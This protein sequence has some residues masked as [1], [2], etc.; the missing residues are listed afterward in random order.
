MRKGE[1]TA[2]EGT[3]GR[4]AASEE[5]RLCSWGPGSRDSNSLGVGTS[6]PPSPSQPPPV[7]GGQP[8]GAAAGRA[9]AGS[10]VRGG[11]AWTLT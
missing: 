5:G 1:G 2:E 3:R 4:E 7:L 9:P 6:L 11:N 8:C 10:G